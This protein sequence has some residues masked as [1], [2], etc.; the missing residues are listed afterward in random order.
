M[1]ILQERRKFGV[2]FPISAI[3]SKEG[4]GTLGEESFQLVDI[5][6]QM[7][8]TVLQLLPLNPTSTGTGNSP[9]MSSSAVAGNT[10]NIS[11]FQ[12]VKDGLLADCV[13]PFNQKGKTPS[14]CSNIDYEAATQWHM[15]WL[16]KAFEG[17]S[18]ETRNQLHEFISEN[19]DWLPD[20]AIF[21]VL[22]EI[23][24]R[25]LWE[26]PEEIRNRN[27]N[28]LEKVKEEFKYKIEFVEYIQFCFFEQ[29]KRF[30]TYVNNKGIRILGD[31]PIYV[32]ADSVEVWC[33]PDMFLLN[34]DKSPSMV[35]G[36]PPDYFS[37]DG[38]LW[39]NPVYCWENHETTDYSWWKWRMK[40]A[41]TMY[42][43]IRLDHFRGYQEYWQ[44]KAGEKTAKNGEWVSGP[45]IKFVREMKKCFPNTGFIAEDL[46]IIGDDVRELLKQSEFPGMKVFV[47][48]TNSYEDSE[49]LPHNAANSVLYSSTH[50]SETL[51]QKI[52]SLNSNDKN[53]ILGYLKVK[54]GEPV[55]L[56][57]L[58]MLFCSASPLLIIPFWDILLMGEEGRF[59]VPG[60]VGNHNWSL[61]L[62]EFGPIEKV[63]GEILRLVKLSKRI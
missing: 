57:I 7:G 19:S 30:K 58:Q 8:A 32:S 36:V 4:I 62:Q 39:G 54:E 56:D 20:F 1:S 3:P 47:F 21:T 53:F 26:W 51:L 59:N 42:D 13:Q 31:V 52:G 44:V 37:E 48:G 27:P 34:P 22:H 5:V 33:N 61:Q 9:Y 40:H 45:G 43:I 23:F 46:G 49:H 63:I 50:D 14:I 11:V 12:M 29:W 55:T 38:Q 25:P 17:I 35:A 15:Y 28:A 16:R 24:Q 10:L 41:T 2:L 18:H 60:T 6:A